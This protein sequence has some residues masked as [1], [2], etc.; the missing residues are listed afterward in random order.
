MSHLSTPLPLSG[1]ANAA[2]PRKGLQCGRVARSAIIRGTAASVVYA[3]L[4]VAGV[5]RCW[6]QGRQAAR[7]TQP[8]PDGAAAERLLRSPLPLPGADDCQAASR[9]ATRAF[10]AWARGDIPAVYGDLH[11][12]STI[13][14][15][16]R[17]GRAPALKAM[18]QW[19]RHASPLLPK[20]VIPAFTPIRS[21]TYGQA[22]AM[23]AI[24]LHPDAARRTNDQPASLAGRVLFMEYR[25]RRQAY[26][27][28]AMKDRGRWWL[29]DQPLEL[30]VPRGLR[31][32]VPS[33]TRR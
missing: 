21:V 30:P 1:R 18:R 27:M 9:L 6:P 2:E 32:S 22:I 26:L 5:P 20:G 14:T 3:V 33:R 7:M 4:L 17:G 29:L 12:E 16:I 23:F 8:Q 10:K 11:P 25:V 13:R 19:H 15:A 28:M 31:Q 24:A